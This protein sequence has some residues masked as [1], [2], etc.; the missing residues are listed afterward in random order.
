MGGLRFALITH[1]V[2]MMVEAL[3]AAISQHYTE[4]GKPLHNLTQEKSSRDVGMLGTR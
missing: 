2:E 4:I 3:T 1:E